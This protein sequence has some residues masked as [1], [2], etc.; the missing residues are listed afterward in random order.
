MVHRHIW[1]F[2]ACSSEGDDHDFCE[3]GV[4]RQHKDGQPMED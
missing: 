2:C 1:W 4:V 3:C